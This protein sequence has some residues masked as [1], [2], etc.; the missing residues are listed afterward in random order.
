MMILGI[1]FA[2]TPIFLFLFVLIYMD[3]YKLVSARTTI[4]TILIGCLAAVLCLTCNTWIL[5]LADLDVRLY[6]RYLAPIIE[7]STK[8]VFILYLVFRRNTGFIVDTAVRGFA[9]GAGFAFVENVYYVSSLPDQNIALWF[10]R[11]CGTAA[12]HGA[13]TAMVG[14]IAKHMYEHKTSRQ[15]IAALVSTIPAIVLHSLFNHFILPPLFSTLVLLVVF[16]LTLIVIY[17][18]SDRATRSWLGEGLDTDVEL[19]RLIMTGE[20]SET[21]IGHYLKSLRDTFDSKVVADMLCYLRFH[22]ELSLQA[23]GI[24]MSQ[25]A[26]IVIPRD[27]ELESKIAE[28]AFLEKSIGRTGRLAIKPFLK[29]GSRENFQITLLMS[30]LETKKG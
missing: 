2:L 4:T 16:P 19:Y 23:K 18:R 10:V 6:S 21:R 9:I 26:G 27:P 22:T 17:D 14:V 1:L 20:I 13:T 15:V 25:Q 8:A 28:M 7:E 29:S 3:S 12:M 5:S 11:G 24:V 30:Q